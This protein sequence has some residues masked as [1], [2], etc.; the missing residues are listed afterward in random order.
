MAPFWKMRRLLPLE[1]QVMDMLL[2]G[3][4]E[5]LSIL[6]EQLEVASVAKRTMTGAGFY[7]EF[8]IP[9]GVRSVSGNPKAMFGDVEAELEGLNLGAGFLLYVMD[10]NLHMLEGYSYEESWPKEILKIKLR[11]SSGSGRDL[12]SIENILGQSKH[13]DSTGFR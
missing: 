2:D 8:E 7:T 10:G 11:Y 5:A 4:S 1:R 12:K 13:S 9:A 6:R 3:E